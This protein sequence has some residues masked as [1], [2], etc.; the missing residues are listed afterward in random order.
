M[1]KQSRF[2]ISL[3]I[4]AGCAA[5]VPD[6]VVRAQVNNKPYQEW[7]VKE[8][9]AL[10]INSSWAQ[11]LEAGV[12]VGGLDTQTAVMG[13][14]VTL[15]LRSAL[16]VRQALVRLRQLKAKYD[17]MGDSDKAAFDTRN[18]PLLECPACDDYYVVSLNPG[19][20]SNKG[21]P[22]ALRTMSLAQVKLNVHLKN[23]NGETRELVNF[24][25]PKVAGDEAVFFFSRLNSKGEPLISPQSRTLTVTFD[26]VIFEGAT[27]RATK[28]DFDVAKMMVDGRVAF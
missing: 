6:P 3:I 21:V 8:A 23:E 22:N 10:L 14:A 7:T 18:K 4:L 24:V 1:R 13:T 9:E 27:I 5:L 15:R 16:P 20:G 12:A 26:P 28:F 11:T 17:K 25:N 2:L 19:P